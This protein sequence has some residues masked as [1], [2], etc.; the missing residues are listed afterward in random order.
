M[1]ADQGEE[2]RQEGAAL[3]SRAQ[4]DQVREFIDFQRQEA[5]AQDAGDAQP[6]L[7]GADAVAPH[8]QHGEAVG[9]GRQQQQRRVHRHQGQVEQVGA[10]RARRVA[11][12]QH[13]I[14]GEQA[15][16]DEAVAHQVDPEAQQGAVLGV[17]FARDVEH[18]L[19]GRRGA[20]LQGG[21][22]GIR[23]VSLTTSCGRLLRARPRRSARSSRA[24]S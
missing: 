5:Q 18:G 7:R 13:A 11:A 21:G 12:A 15:G 8:L 1:R 14:D 6:D 20:A 10:G 2:G 23:H 4:V 17:V 19:G 9:D 24:C 16:K 22:Q 3:R